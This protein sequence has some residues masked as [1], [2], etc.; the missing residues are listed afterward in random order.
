[1]EISLTVEAE[2]IIRLAF[3]DN[4][5]GVSLEAQDKL[6]MPNFTTKTTGSGIG[7]AVSKRGIEHAGGRIWFETEIEI[8]TTFFIELPLVD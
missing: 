2:G 6:F 4:G 5:E 8:G 3:K 1:M 7:L